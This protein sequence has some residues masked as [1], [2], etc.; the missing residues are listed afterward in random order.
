MFCPGET[1]AHEFTIPFAKSEIAKIVATY[2]QQD[3]VV[4]I[5]EITSGFRDG[6]TSTESTFSVKLSQA[7]TL[8]FAEHCPYT[9]Q[10]NVLTINGTRS[11]SKEMYD[12]TGP[13]QYKRVITSA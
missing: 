13:Q 6:E 11:A 9:I 2:K 7:D 8:L 4:K 10:L 3:H 12:K 1:V 5:V